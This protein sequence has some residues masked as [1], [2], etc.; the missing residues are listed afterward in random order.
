M[1]Y[2]NRIRTLEESHRLADNQL[3]Q[4][5]KSGS[6]DTEKLQKLSEAKAK[7]LNELRQLRRLQWDH[8]HERVDFE[9]D[10]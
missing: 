5:E 10:R 2:T 1:P 4:L 8:D 9:D 3:F 6:K 7:Y